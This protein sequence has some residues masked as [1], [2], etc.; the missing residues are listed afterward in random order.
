MV[1]KKV[2]KVIS[3]TDSRERNRKIERK[4]EKEL[5]SFTEFSLISYSYL[6]TS[7]LS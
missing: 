2:F 5:D 3:M 4:E 7:Q 6:L 1:K